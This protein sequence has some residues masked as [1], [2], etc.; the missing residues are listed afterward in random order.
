MDWTQSK[1]A[2]IKKLLELDPSSSVAYK[3]TCM[4]VL[5]EFPY[6]KVLSSDTIRIDQMTRIVAF[7]I[8]TKCYVKDGTA[9]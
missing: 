9:S 6:I 8:L 3:E 2:K 1:L 5:T 4:L 7:G